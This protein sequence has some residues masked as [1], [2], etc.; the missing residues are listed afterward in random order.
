MASSGESRSLPS[1]RRR[2]VAL[3]AVGC[4]VLTLFALAAVRSGVA[5]ALGEEPTGHNVAVTGPP[6]PT[7]HSKLSEH[8]R[9]YILSAAAQEQAERLIQAAIN[10]DEGATELI[11]KLAPDWYGRVVFTK[12]WNDLEAVA[13]ASN[14]VRVRAAAIET[15]LAMANVPQKTDSVTRLINATEK[16]PVN[17]P[18]YARLLG[19]LGNRGVQPERIR[20]WLLSWA[21]E[22]PLAAVEAPRAALEEE[23]RIAVVQALALIADDEDMHELLTMLREYP[24]PRVRRQVVR[25]ISRTGMF[26]Q[27]QRWHAIPPLLDLTLDPAVDD[28]TR[29][30]VFDCLRDITG[31]SLPDDRNAWHTWFY[32]ESRRRTLGID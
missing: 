12:P 10:R 27:S 9:E 11:A 25:S 1:L 13:M 5:Q 15:H 26:T 17:R 14:D 21:H 22:S 4:S 24:S 32:E 20:E 2:A 18:H 30:E 31:A 29:H 23:A 28:L 3:C 19:M 16:N 6:L 8:E 7:T